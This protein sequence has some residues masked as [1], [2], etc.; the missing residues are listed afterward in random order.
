MSLVE[1]LPAFPFVTKLMPAKSDAWPPE[2]E[3]ILRHLWEVEK[4][5]ARQCAA[6][7]GVTRN[8]VIGKVHRM[9]LRKHVHVSGPRAPRPTRRRTSTIGIKYLPRETT[10]PQFL[11]PFSQQIANTYTTVG[12]PIMR[13]ERDRCY[14][15]D[16]GLYCGHLTG[17]PKQVKSYCPAH[18]ALC[19]ERRAR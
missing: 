9:N 10:E 1:V 11:I 16:S 6:R 12:L 3:N 19:H 18:D 15:P 7:I 5:S 14:Y 4:L 8:A 2:R 17:D 13:M